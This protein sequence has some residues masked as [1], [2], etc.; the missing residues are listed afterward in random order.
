MPVPF[1]CPHCGEQTLVD[2]QFAGR[3]GPCIGC[4]KLIV[5]PYFYS[6]VVATLA[7]PP[8]QIG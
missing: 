7:S 4:G 6:G 3:S 8:S 5:V 1:A 2:E